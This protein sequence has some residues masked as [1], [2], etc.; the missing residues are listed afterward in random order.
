ML[1]ADIKIRNQKAQAPQA[2]GFFPL[3][4]FATYTGTSAAIKAQIIG[5]TA[6]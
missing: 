6:L 4:F 3:R 5:T 2:L 1:C